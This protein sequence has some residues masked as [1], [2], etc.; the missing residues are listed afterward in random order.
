MDGTSPIGVPHAAEL[1]GFAAAAIGSDSVA[2]D[3]A[4][5]AAIAALGPAAMIDAAAVI[6]GFDGITRIAD[7]T[8][9]PLEP[10]KA[11]QT[12]GVREALRIDSF[13][14]AKW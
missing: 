5:A 8:G 13:L 10:P 1:L 7:A 2:L 11:A 9:I 3:R 4:R 6:A 14:S 12:A